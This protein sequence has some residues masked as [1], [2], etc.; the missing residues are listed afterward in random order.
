M[1]KRKNITPPTE[2]KRRGLITLSE[3]SGVLESSVIASLNPLALAH[4]DLEQLARG[5]IKDIPRLLAYTDYDDMEMNIPEVKT[6]LDVYAD[7]ACMGTEGDEK[8]FTIVAKDTKV[9]DTLNDLINRLKLPDKVWSIARDVKKYGD[10]FEE[11]ELNKAQSSIARLKTLSVY[12]I[13]R[14]H[15]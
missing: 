3:D 9:T 12:K 14:A 13:G 11:I 7:V 6:A 5:E 10:D 1:S 8:A 2:E 15:V 4:L